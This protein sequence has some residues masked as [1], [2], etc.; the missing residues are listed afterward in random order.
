MDM[1]F[2]S[3]SSEMGLE[4]CLGALAP[5]RLH[6]LF[7]CYGRHMNVVRASVTQ[8]PVGLKTDHAGGIK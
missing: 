8:I 4:Q 2:E 6:P 3:L 7:T 1:P 5:W